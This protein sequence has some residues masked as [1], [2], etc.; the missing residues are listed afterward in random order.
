MEHLYLMLIVFI[1]WTKFLM[2]I[3]KKKMTD[4]FYFKWAAKKTAL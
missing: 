2:A 1:K 4:E 3:L